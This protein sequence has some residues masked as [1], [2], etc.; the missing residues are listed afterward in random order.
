[1][2]VQFAYDGQIR[3]FVLQFIRMLSNFQVEYGQDSNGDITLQTIP[4]YYGDQDRQAAMILRNNSENTINAVPAMATYISGLVYDRERVL[5]PYMESSVRIREQVFNPITQSYTG[6]QDG[7]YTVERFMPSPYKL[8]MKVDIWT[9]NTEQKHQILEQILPLFNPALDIQNSENIVDW[10]SLSAVFLTDTQYRN[11]SVPSGSDDSTIDIAT[12]SFEMPIWINLPSKV[13]K[14]GVVTQIIASIY[15]AAGDLSEDVVSSLQGLVSQQKYAPLNYKVLFMGNTLKLYPST[16]NDTN[17][18]V[19][20]NPIPW[21]GLVNVYGTLTNGVSQVRLQFEHT[22][23]FHEIVGVVAYDPT[24][25]TS[26]LFTPIASTLPANTL[27]P[28]NAIIDPRN[29]TVNSSIT[30][31]AVGT[32]YL[33]LNPIGDANSDPAVAWAGTTGTNLIANANDIIEWNGSYWTVAFDSREPSIQYVTNL[34]TSVQ[35]CWQNSQW[36]KSYEGLY[37]SGEWSLV[38]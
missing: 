29:V 3:R 27:A 6:T 7:M 33:I 18:Q 30:N 11:R 26:L 23:G 15:N 31:P 32:R 2:A 10:S 38:L 22:D 37:G 14:M 21:N 28:V 25:P 34:T 13:K 20:G 16:S 4:V 35:Y 19:S 5:N 36:A 1:M 12:L 24:D 17:D 9:S 8:Q